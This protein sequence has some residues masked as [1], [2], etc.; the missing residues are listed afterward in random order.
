MPTFDYTSRDYQSIREDLLSRASQLPIG[1]EWTTRASSDFGVML[2]DLWAYMGDVLHFYVDRAAAETY[3]GTATQRE[4]VLALSNLL[5]YEP[6][7][8]RSANATVTVERTNLS[9]TSTINIPYGT[10]FIAPARDDTETTV[11][12]TTTQ[13]ASMGASVTSLALLVTE[14]LFVSKEAPVNT[15]SANANTSNGAPN[16]QFTLRYSNV[17]PSSVAVTVYEGPLSNGTP[18][19]VSYQYVSRL[20]DYTSTDKVFTVVTDADGIVNIVF[21]NGI[22]GKIPT[23]GTQVLVDY[24]VSSGSAGNISANRITAFNSNTVTG[25]YV[26]ASTASSGGYDSESISSLKANVPLL[27]RTQ[28]R[29]VSLQDFKDLLLRIPSVVKGTATNSGANVTLYPIPY[30]ADY[31]ST[32]FGNTITIDSATSSEVTKYF[33][34]RIV[35]GA[36]VSVAS[37][38]TLTPVYVSATVNVLPGYVQ[39]W[40]LEDVTATLDQFFDFNNVYFGQ[41][42]SLGEVYRAVMSVEGVDYVNITV[43]NT[44]NSGIVSGNAITAGATNLLRKA[45]NYTITLS[46]GVSA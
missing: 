30:Q 43:F 14:G 4:S 38:V 23:T 40:V 20:I 45:A 15:L 12:F 1:S 44:T 31:L 39:R 8:I 34:S 5:D 27:F 46:G 19:A 26:K 21:G 22:N 17:A 35:L 24:I 3:L 13:S 2:V 29:A 25:V 16:Q 7:A 28:D 18:T 42:L 33:E 41:T 10:S 9:D 11:Y 6:L 36:S 32:S 37:T